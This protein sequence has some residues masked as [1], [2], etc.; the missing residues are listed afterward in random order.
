MCITALTLLGENIFRKIY[1]KGLNSNLNKKI[2]TPAAELLKNKS[3]GNKK[4]MPVK[5]ALALSSFAIPLIEFTL[6][7]IKNLMTLKV[8]KQG[9]FDN[10]ANLD[11]SNKKD[12]ELNK[13]VEKS[14]KKN[15]LELLLLFRMPLFK[16]HACKERN[17]IRNS[18]KMFL[19]I[20]AP[21]TKL[22]KKNQR[23]CKFL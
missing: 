21:G 17:I 22:F 23:Q 7:Y 9:N 13:R 12:T 16:L 18:C 3:L 19:K 5:A 2:S 14:A 11:K 4:L 15:I 1:S 10:I 8:F 6:N 20:L